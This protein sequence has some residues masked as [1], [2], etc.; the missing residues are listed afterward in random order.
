MRDKSVDQHRLL[1]EDNV[2]VDKCIEVYKKI[3]HQVSNYNMPIKISQANRDDRAG[4]HIKGNKGFFDNSRRPLFR[5]FFLFVK[6]TLESLPAQMQV[7]SNRNE[8]DERFD[9]SQPGGYGCRAL[10]SPMGF[11]PVIREMLV[12][13][14]NI[15]RFIRSAYAALVL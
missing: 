9:N 12:F 10:N 5:S 14:E 13:E 8:G 15:Y 7:N 6:S 3:S 2:L 4:H 1:R 11:I